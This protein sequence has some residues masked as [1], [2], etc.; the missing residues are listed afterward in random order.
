MEIL[1][2]GTPPGERTYVVTCNN[3]KTK[4]RFKKNEARVVP[5]WRD[6][7]Y[8]SI[9]CPTAGCRQEVSATTGSYER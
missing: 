9:Q 6:G 3:C 7:D 8:L 2:Q 4:F 1:F 5:D